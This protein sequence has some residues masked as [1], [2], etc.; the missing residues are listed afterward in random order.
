MRTI[1]LFI[2]ILIASLLAA[3]NHHAH[4]SKETIRKADSKLNVIKS[5]Y[6]IESLKKSSSKI[7]TFY[8]FYVL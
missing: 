1:I 8:S 7:A 2:A 6:K 3:L 5:T 4:D